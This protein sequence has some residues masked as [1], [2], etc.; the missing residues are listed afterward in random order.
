MLG[1]ED[2]WF[3]RLFGLV[4]DPTTSDERR[5]AFADFLAHDEPDFAGYCDRVRAGAPGLFPA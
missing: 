2:G 1:V 3:P 4:L 5:A